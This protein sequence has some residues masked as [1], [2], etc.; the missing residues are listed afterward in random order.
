[1]IL[2]RPLGWSICAGMPHL[3]K[4]VPTQD[5]EKDA[6]N[7]AKLLEE[8]MTLAEDSYGVKGNGVCTDNASSMKKMRKTIQE[9]KPEVE[10]W[11][12][13][14]HLLDLLGQELTPDTIMG[15][16]IKVQ[17]HFRN[18]HREG[19]CLREKANTVK[20]QL[21]CATRWSSQLDCLESFLKNRPAYIEVCEEIE[22]MDEAI[23]RLV[24]DYALSKNIKDL[25]AQLEPIRVA[26]NKL[27]S[28][29]ATLADAVE[30]WLDLESN[31]L[32]QP[33]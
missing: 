21:P 29:S 15:R 14:A 26:L 23:K 25:A 17:K 16:V 20:P 27:Q 33:H 19:A 1:M 12:C 5:M 28:D 8:A 3:L 13:S 6:E 31:E 18:H 10:T 32:L 24:N 30:V 22:N 9:K 7:C 4:A 2:N 11:G